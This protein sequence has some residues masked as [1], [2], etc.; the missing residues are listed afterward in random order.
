MAGN[1]GYFGHCEE[2][3]DEAIHNPIGALDCFASLA[4]TI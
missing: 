3:S 2:Q 4:M 1:R